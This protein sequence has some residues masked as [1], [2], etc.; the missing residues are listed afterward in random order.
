MLD[1][2]P[3]S[4]SNLAKHALCLPSGLVCPSQCVF[5]SFTILVWL[6]VKFACFAS[7]VIAYMWIVFY[8]FFFVYTVHAVH[9][10]DIKMCCMDVVAV[11]Q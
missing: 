6:L 3:Q 7:V 4:E 5:I 10:L 2:R 9:Y 1:H 8:G 11:L